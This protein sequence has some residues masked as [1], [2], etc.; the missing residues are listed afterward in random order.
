MNISTQETARR[1][2]SENRGLVA[3][4]RHQKQE[5][6]R[7]IEDARQTKR[8][9]EEQMAELD[10]Q[11]QDLLFFLKAQE[12]VSRSCSLADCFCSGKARVDREDGVG[13][14]DR[15]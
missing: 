7:L 12:E 5:E 1:V 9:C 6:A 15:L 10:G 3:E 4:Q 13:S 8:Q 2:R 11:M 14:F